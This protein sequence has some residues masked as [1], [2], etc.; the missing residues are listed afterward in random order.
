VVTRDTTFGRIGESRNISPAVKF[1]GRVSACSC[2]I[3]DS[4]DL[5]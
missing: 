5:N 3:G 2:D 4:C 1:R